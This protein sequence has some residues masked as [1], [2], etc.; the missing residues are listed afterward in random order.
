MF[1]VHF[2]TEFSTA[3]QREIREAPFGSP[4]PQGLSYFTTTLMA[5]VYSSVRGL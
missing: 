3:L 4:R 5:M 1:D 2:L